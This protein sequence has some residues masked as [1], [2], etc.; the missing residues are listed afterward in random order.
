MRPESQP[1]VSVLTP[2]YNCEDYLSECIESVLAQ[3]YENWE[4]CIVNNCSADRTLEIAEAYA[5][6]DNRIRIH[7][8]SDFVGIG[9]NGNIAFQQM[10]PNSKYCK[11]VYADDWLFPECIMK[12]VKLAEAHSTVAIVGAYGLLGEAVS[13][14]GLP[15]TSSVVSGREISRWTL[16]GKPYV[17]GNPTSLLL[18]SDLVRASEPFYDA[19]NSHCDSEACLRILRSWDF[20]FVHQVLSYNRIREGSGRSFSRRYNT[21]LPNNIDRLLKFGPTVLSQEELSARLKYYLAIYYDYLAVSVFMLREKEFWAFH[22]EKMERM[23]HPLS[24][25]RLAAAVCS[26][27]IDYLFNP[28]RTIEGLLRKIRH[29][30]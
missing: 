2:V 24:L 18:R 10:S 28:K 20:G 7:N 11:V 6:K 25:P 17:F 8:N 15:Y 19:S 22:R 14:D 4:Y 23:G 30:S 21:Y 27:A 13:W 26:K 3:T 29:G 5:K 1:L 12:M 9:Q 16:L